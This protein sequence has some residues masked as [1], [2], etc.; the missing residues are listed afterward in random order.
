MPKKPA[1]KRSE[2]EALHAE[3]AEANR[4]AR[5]AQRRADAGRALATIKINGQRLVPAAEAWRLQLDRDAVRGRKIRDAA[6]AGGRA[7][8]RGPS[9]EEVRA[10]VLNVHEASPNLRRSIVFARV[11]KQLGMDRTTVYRRVPEIKW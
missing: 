1:K 3:L 4:L 7:T 8:R 6:A 2:L 5:A 11:G 9:D 10:A